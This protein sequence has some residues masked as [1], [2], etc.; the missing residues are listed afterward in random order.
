MGIRRRTPFLQTLLMGL[1]PVALGACADGDSPATIGVD[2]PDPAAGAE[3]FTTACA[4]CH[5]SGDG[6]DLALF[7]FADTTIVRRA[8]AH[9]D[10]ATALD[11]VAH[12]R[13][14]GVASMGEERRPFQPAVQPVADDEAFAVALFG[15]DAWPV[16]DEGTLSDIDPR[17]V[18]TAVAFP[19]WSDEDSNL[20]WMPDAPLPP[21]LLDARGGMA[22]ATLAGYYAAPT[23]DNL[24]RTVGLLRALSRDPAG[25]GA[26]CRLDEERRLADPEACFEID[27]WIA[28]LAAQH[29]LR[30]GRELQGMPV[31]R[32]AFWDVGMAARRSLVSNLDPVDNAEA[33]WGVWMYLGWTFEPGRHASVYTASALTRAGLPRHA[34]FVALRSLVARPP[35][36]PMPFQDLRVAASSAPD[37][38]LATAYETGLSALEARERRGMGPDAPEARADAA[39]ALE[40]AAAVLRRRLGV[41]ASRTL[42][43]RT[44]SLVNAL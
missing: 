35:G 28:A 5:G 40:G 4:E 39:D 10:T 7:G 2:L 43:E 9:V 26:A 22:R 34:T 17:V 6:F 14:L 30:N 31:V 27:R 3:A 42:V 20:D 33:N 23:D 29:M 24:A 32:D 8:V 12:V 15:D 16:M 38:W 21:D 25:A 41:D 18:A 1:A 13:S 37:R 11:I 44:L 19:R 36:T